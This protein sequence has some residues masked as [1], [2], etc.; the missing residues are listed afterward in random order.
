MKKVFSMLLALCLACVLLPAQAE[1]LSPVCT[2]YLVRGEKNGVVVETAGMI[3][4]VLTI[5]ED[6][7]CL[8]KIT[9][10]GTEMEDQGTWTAA[11][12]G[13]LITDSTGIPQMLSFAGEEL[14]M[15]MD[16]TLM[17]FSHTEPEAP[18]T[19]V[20]EKVPAEA[21]EQ[22]NGSWRISRV[23]AMGVVTSAENMGMDQ[24][25]NMEILNGH[26]TENGQHEGNP[27]AT[28]TDA[29]FTDGFLQVSK[30]TDGLTFRMTYALLEDGTLGCFMDI[31]GMEVTMI[32][33]RTDAATEEPAA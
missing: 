24:A 7:S 5:H 6:G 31:M 2:W 8:T 33:E 10:Y 4:M 13:I 19:T 9:M 22:F 3:N 18:D 21:V 27:V 28:E 32:Y 1:E 17:Y 26:I 11:D 25:A 15:D 23:M 16:G 20:A 30:E 29:E 12:G 14:T